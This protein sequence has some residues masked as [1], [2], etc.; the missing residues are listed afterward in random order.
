MSFQSRTVNPRDHRQPLADQ[1]GATV[2]EQA[3]FAEGWTHL[4][5]S[6]ARRGGLTERFAGPRS[7]LRQG[8]T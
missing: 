1:A 2:L 8:V 6:W 4:I 5:R 7:K 3:T